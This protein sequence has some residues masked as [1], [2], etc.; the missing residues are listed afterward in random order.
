MSVF[1][2]VF[3]PRP[4]GLEEWLHHISMPYWEDKIPSKPVIF[5]KMLLATSEDK[6][7]SK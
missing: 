7:N 1:P 2:V 4:H 3:W 5:I 6:S